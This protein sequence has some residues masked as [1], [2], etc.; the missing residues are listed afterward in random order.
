MELR[1]TACQAR[2]DGPNNACHVDSSLGHG[3]APAFGRVP[4]LRVEIHRRSCILQRCGIKE[5]QGA[6][7]GSKDHLAVTG[8]GP[9][10]VEEIAHG[11]QLA[12][13]KFDGNKAPP[14]AL[15]EIHGCHR[16]NAINLIRCPEQGQRKNGA[17]IQDNWRRWLRIGPGANDVATIHALSQINPIGTVQNRRSRIGEEARPSRVPAILQVRCSH[18]GRCHEHQDQSDCKHR[19]HRVQFVSTLGKVFRTRLLVVTMFQD[20][21]TELPDLP[22]HVRQVRAGPHENFHYLIGD[23]A[24]HEAAL[25]DPAFHVADLMEAA[26]EDGWNVTDAWFTHAHWDHIGGIVEAV[27]LGVERIVIGQAAARADDVTS[28]VEAGAFLLALPEDDTTFQ[29]GALRIAALHTPGH[30][31]EG[32]CFL[33]DGR[34][35]LAGDTLFVDTCGR[36]DFPGGDTDAMF[37]SMAKLRGLPDDVVLLPGHDYAAHAWRRLGNQKQENPALATMDR[38]A[39][40]QLHCLTH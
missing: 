36:T 18:Y 30:Q 32:T 9:W 12:G 37:A 16:T 23:E 11:Q 13:F 27:D 38:D 25:V 21:S 20:V 2:I 19:P 14:T 34:A 31:P 22:F 15:H 28:A 29:L 7:H 24:S 10:L 6:P 35:L 4:L 17:A 40:G 33:V 3:H 8:H 39:F 26:R 5:V 1:I